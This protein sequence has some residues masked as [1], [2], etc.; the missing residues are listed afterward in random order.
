MN[1]RKFL[2]FFSAAMGAGALSQSSSAQ[3]WAKTL[4][5]SVPFKPV[6][7]PMPLRTSQIEPLQQAQRFKTYT[8]ADDLILPEGYSYQV[9]EAWGDLGRAQCHPCS[10]R[11]SLSQDVF[12]R[13]VDEIYEFQVRLPPVDY[14]NASRRRQSWEDCGDQF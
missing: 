10:N 6:L 3:S 9:L 5:P 8:I 13:R 7:G 1:R 12:A 11:R 4:M 14:A 2:A